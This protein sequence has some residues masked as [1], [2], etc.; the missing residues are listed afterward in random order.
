MAITDDILDDTLRHA[1]YLER[2]K[3]GVVN[4]V[5]GLLNNS[6]DKYVVE[7]LDGEIRDLGES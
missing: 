4:K 6:N 3:S 1:H 7:L 2:Y 5:V